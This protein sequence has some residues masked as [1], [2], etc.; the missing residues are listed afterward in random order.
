MQNDGWMNA[1]DYN[2]E[3]PFGSFDDKEKVE[4]PERSE[5]V[6]KCPCCGSTVAENNRGFFCEGADCSF[7]LWK[8]NRFFE[9]ITKEMTR[10]VAE[11]LLKDGWVDMQGC[12]SVRTGNKFN[13]RLVMRP[14]ENQRPQFNIEFPKKKQTE[15]E[16]YGRDESR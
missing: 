7:A 1:E 14:D 8:N 2:D 13:C 11:K 15:D 10:E 16:Y 12:K 9:A 6:G 4:A 3:L 5:V